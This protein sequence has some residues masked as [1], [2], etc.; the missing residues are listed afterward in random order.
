VADGPNEVAVLI[1]GERFRFW[2]ELHT[3]QSIDSISTIELGAP[4]EPSR[5]GFRQTFRPLSFAPLDVSV[6]GSALFTGT[7]INAPPRL[8]PDR[9]TITASG[10]AK[11]G[12]LNDCTPP[13]SAFPLEFDGQN[14]ADIAATLA[15]P[16]G[17]PVHVEAPAGAIFDRAELSPGV[18]ILSFL[19]TLAGQRNRIWGDTPQ[20]ALA[21]RT[22][23]DTGAPVAILRE[24]E[25]PLVSVEP[26][27]QPQQYFSH[28]TGLESV[29]IGTL[30]SQYTVRNRH[31][32]AALRPFVYVAPDVLGGEI[33][34]A[35]NAK[36]G[37]MWA[38]VVSY[39]ASVSTWRDKAGALWEP[40]T[41]IVINAPGAMVY[42]DYEFL[43]RSVRLSRMG[44]RETAELGLVL[45]GAFRGETPE[46]LPWD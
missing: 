6:G 13:A 34:D 33:R 36:F 20:G 38:N 18:P 8:S 35:V 7:L 5:V 16:F 31:L 45:P 1:G 3:S 21:L 10:Y 46:T 12:V 43:I 25:S 2:T 17:I 14:V 23:V 37:R 44:D 28:I 11:P 26:S 41:T 24:G 27:F 39:A 4:F 40:N 9:K 42:E 22:S 30:G 32:T 19:T 15:A 29:F